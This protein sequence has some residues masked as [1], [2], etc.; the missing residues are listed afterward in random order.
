M[1]LSIA[2]KGTAKG[3][4]TAQKMMWQGADRVKKAKVQT[5]RNE[6]EAL[7]MKDNEQLDDFY[8]KLNGL[9]THIRA[10]G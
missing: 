7:A 5:L 1:V 4:C 2:D 9:V 8:L 10:L 3:V 6:F